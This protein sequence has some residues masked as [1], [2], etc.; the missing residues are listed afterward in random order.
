M[1]LSGRRVKQRIPAD[2]RNLAWADD[3]AKFGSNYLA[4]F[5]WDA[6]KGLGVDGEGRTSHI[7]VSHKL[8]MLGIGAAH[9]KDPNGLAWKQNRD[10]ENLLKRLNENV[11]VESNHSELVKEEI[12]IAADEDSSEPKDVESLQRNEK[13]RKRK[14]EKAE[15]KAK[16]RKKKDSED[17]DMKPIKRPDIPIP[18]D[19]AEAP[20]AVA[21]PHRARAIAS[22]AIAS[23]SSV[24]IA[25]ILGIAPSTSAIPSGSATPVES[26]KLTVIEDDDTSLEKL[27]TSTKS[28][29]DYF[30]EKLLAKS[31][32]SGTQSPVTTTSYS[33]EDNSYAAPR[34]GLGASR[35]RLDVAAQDVDMDTQRHGLS[36]F[37][38]LTSSTFLSA[39]FTK[40]V[41]DATP[42]TSDTPMKS[43]TEEVSEDEEDKVIRESRKRDRKEKKRQKIGTD[44][45]KAAE[46][47]I[48]DQRIEKTEKKKEKK[49]KGSKDKIE[50]ENET[51]ALSKEERRRLRK[52]KKSK[53][54]SS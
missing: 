37:S 17:E 24:H 25:E 13:K 36:K 32:K 41:A 48:P 51:T 4:K 43:L 46:E 28:V 29:A 33:D 9:Q 53:E 6:S 38:S 3:A 50:A 1:G 22:K 14:E 20:S 27:T 49:K 52:E 21:K 19:D 47:D 31:S 45:N 42:S 23:K 35:L 10:F 15:E 26:G 12:T 2:P 11:Q 54:S 8:D 34:G 44:E 7:K 30:K 18:K 39:L 5:G 40:P 16:K